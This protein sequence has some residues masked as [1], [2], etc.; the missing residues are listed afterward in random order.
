MGGLAAVHQWSRIGCH[1]FIGGLA[2]VTRDLLPF[3]MAVGNRANLE[4]INLVGMRRRNFSKSEIDEVKK[5]YSILFDKNDLEF[6]NRIKKLKDE[7]FKLNSAK[8]ITNFVSVETNRAYV[9]PSEV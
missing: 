3:G 8:I 2:A 5:A 6:K 7:E 1:S 4:G 9:S